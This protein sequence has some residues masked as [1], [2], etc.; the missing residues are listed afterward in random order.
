MQTSAS[1]SVPG[2]QGARGAA[3]STGLTAPLFLGGGAGK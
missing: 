3:T 2:G 1:G